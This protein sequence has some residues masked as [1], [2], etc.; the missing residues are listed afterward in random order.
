VS[1]GDY[2]EHLTYLIFLKMAEEYRKPPYSRDVGIPEK[3]TWDRLKQLRGSELDTHYR[4]LLEE[5]EKNRGCSGR[6]S[7]KPR[8]R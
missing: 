5:L 4:E 2:L 3:Y 7:S 6:S 1:Y 8:T